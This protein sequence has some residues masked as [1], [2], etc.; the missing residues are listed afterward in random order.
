MV[1]YLNQLKEWEHWLEDPDHQTLLNCKC[2]ELR[3]YDSR[4]GY[5]GPNRS[6]FLSWLVPDTI[7]GV[8]VSYAAFWHDRLYLVGGTWRERRDADFRFLG[9]IRDKVNA[10]D[11]PG[12][13]RYFAYARSVSYLTAVRLFGWSCFRYTKTGRSK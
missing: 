7:W 9:I 4:R 2:P 5:A 10:A 11:L 8:S 3:E 13:I 1:D 6:R 12:L